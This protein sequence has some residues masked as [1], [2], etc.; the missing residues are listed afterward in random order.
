MIAL[1][2]VIAV[3]VLV[4]YVVVV[5]VVLLDVLDRNGAGVVSDYGCAGDGRGVCEGVDY[6]LLW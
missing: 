5:M 2:V 1:M 3:E 4:M 6:C